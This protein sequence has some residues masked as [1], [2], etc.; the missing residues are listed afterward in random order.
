MSVFVYVRSDQ[1]MVLQEQCTD[2]D[3]GKLASGQLQR[4][5]LVSSRNNFM[6]RRKVLQNKV[7]TFSALLYMQ[8]ACYS[9]GNICSLRMKMFLNSLLSA[10][11]KSLRATQ[12]TN[13]CA[14][15]TKSNFNV[16]RPCWL[17]W[18]LMRERRIGTFTFPQSSMFKPL[19]FYS[20]ILSKF[21]FLC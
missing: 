6:H 3:N 11:F 7:S 13:I 15:L 17:H 10:C 9:F 19:P 5:N 4:L 18:M 12:V 21:P 14:Y 20:W 1:W 2:L 16:T 8:I